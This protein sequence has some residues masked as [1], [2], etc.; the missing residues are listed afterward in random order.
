MCVYN[1]LKGDYLFD[2]K[3]DWI[4]LHMAKQTKTNFIHLNRVVRN[5]YPYY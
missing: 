5:Y 4:F 1:V 3:L 2:E